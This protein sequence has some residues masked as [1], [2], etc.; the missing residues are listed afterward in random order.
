MEEEGGYFRRNH[1]VPLPEAR[2]LEHLNEP[3]L[4]ASCKQEEQ[5]IIAGREQPIGAAMVIE[6]EHLQPLPIEGFDLAA[7]SGSP[8]VN[9]KRLRARVDELLFGAAAGQGPMS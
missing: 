6:R 7:V 3:L 1:M 4:V 8:K 5:R 2:D 9:G